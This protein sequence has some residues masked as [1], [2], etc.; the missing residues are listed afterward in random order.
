[1]PKNASRILGLVFVLLVFLLLFSYFF[2][3]EAPE[4]VSMTRT[5]EALGEAERGAGTTVDSAKASEAAPATS[6]E[7]G[8]EEAEIAQ[9]SPPSSDAVDDAAGGAWIRGRVTDLAGL[10]IAD[11]E[12]L[13]GLESKG[14]QDLH[15]FSGVNGAFEIGGLPEEQF[16]VGARYPGYAPSYV[17]A[18][19][20]RVS[21]DSTRI[22]LGRGGSLEGHVTLAGKPLS[23]CD[24]RVV[25]LADL[26]G[27]RK[28]RPDSAGYYQVKFLTPGVHRVQ[29]IVYNP[30]E[31]A[32]S[33]SR[34]IH[35]DV[36]IEEGR[37]TE[38][39]FDFSVLT[40][41]IEGRITVNGVTP[42]EASI[43]LSLVGEN[44]DLERQF[45]QS[46]SDGYYRFEELGFGRAQ[47]AVR[48]ESPD[49]R[50]FFTAVRNI[51]IPESEVVVFDVE[52]LAGAVITGRVSGVPENFE[53]GAIVMSGDVE[54]GEFSLEAVLDLYETAT[55]TVDLMGS[56]EFHATG[57]EPG[58]YTV[59]M[60]AIK[61]GTSDPFGEIFGGSYVVELGEGEEVFIEHSFE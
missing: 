54:V 48:A 10:A 28:L 3:L 2:A 8:V 44:M 40:S 39:N 5:E 36:V 55:V 31:P 26:S 52:L 12:I 19:A 57:L 38:A 37:T 60:M 45:T 53:A 34:S 4:Q 20:S 30:A 47:L 23:D 49:G 42:K 15:A 22:V 25:H 18:V 41:S 43:A 27:R 17:R 24:I 56:D 21:G 1:M 11:A 59:L 46:D 33:T 50:I 61:Q 6:V 51:S 14:G 35:S 9:A 32:V 7:L 16:L 29:L 13:L 58:T